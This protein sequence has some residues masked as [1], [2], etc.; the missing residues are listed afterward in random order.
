MAS[1]NFG[2]DLHVVQTQNGEL[3]IDGCPWFRFLKTQKTIHLDSVEKITLLD[4][5]AFS[6]NFL[7]FNWRGE[8]HD[9][10]LAIHLPHWS[11]TY[12]HYRL[13]EES[14]TKMCPQI[15]F[16]RV[17]NHSTQWWILANVVVFLLALVFGFCHAQIVPNSGGEFFLVV[18][19]VSL[20]SVPVCCI[21]GVGLTW[22]VLF[23]AGGIGELLG[24]FMSF[25]QLVTEV[26]R[27]IEVNEDIRE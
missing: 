16:E 21:F 15:A 2:K 14:V 24:S 11:E 12:T 22:L 23:V 5:G 20:V 3:I 25:W 27:V 19:V 10:P 8:I 4:S 9:A 6:G 18:L 1:I 7:C 13:L 26:T 17:T